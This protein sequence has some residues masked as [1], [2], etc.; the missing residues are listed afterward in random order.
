MEEKEEFDF[1]EF[2]KQAIAG[3]YAG[4]PFN[5]ERGI[6]APLM[7]HFLEAALAGELESHLVESKAKGI[8]NRKNGKASK[9]VKS[10]SGEFELESS[11]DRSGTFEPMI[12]PKR[13]V[14]ITEELEAK[15]IGLYGLGMSTRDISS[16]L[17]ELY[18]MDISATQLSAI[19]DKVIPAMQEWRS[20]PL[21]SIYPIVFMDC[22][23]Y[24]VKEDGRVVSRA[25]YNILGID[26]E[27]KKDLI[28][29][30]VAETEGAKFWLS[31]LTDLKRRGV[32]DILIACID[33]LKGFPE[34][35]VTV[36]PQTQIQLCIVH[37]IRNSLKY[38]PEK[39][40]K[41]F[42]ADLKLVYSAVNKE[43]GFRQLES[44]EA[45]WSKKYIIAVQSW[46][47]NWENLSSF[48]EY[49]EDIRRLIYTTNPI[50]GFHRQ[51]R[52]V[53]KTKG[54]FTSDT[55][56]LKLIYLVVQRISQKWTMPVRNWGVTLSQL[57]IIFGDRLKFHNFE[58]NSLGVNNK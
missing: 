46:F 16:H 20:R 33:G 18:Q 40:K 43:E 22:I 34:A 41:A 10:L 26:L 53:T 45:K 6:F 12:L 31:V 35:I 2:K 55:A 27:G 51:V 1:D 32:E 23:H 14:I 57:Y 11:R 3:M 13:Q 39:D 58:K 21:E 15:V 44:L 48:Y 54:S 24:K 19:T 52:K 25:I 9:Q 5:G 29:M 30:Y 47:T 37:Q 50:E 42:I 4:K 7:K 36:Y 38:V 56:L 49:A 28:G 8:A 17:K